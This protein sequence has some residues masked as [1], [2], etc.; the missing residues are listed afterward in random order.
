MLCTKLALLAFL[1]YLL[2]MLQA[3]E[4]PVRFK[5]QELL[6]SQSPPMS[7]SELSRRSGISLVTINAIANNRTRQVSLETIDSISSALGVEP[8]AL[9]VKKGKRG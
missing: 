5:L 6:D 2:L 7:Q 4:M 9:F 1:L 3:P 8:G